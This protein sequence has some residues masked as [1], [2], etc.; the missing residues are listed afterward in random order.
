MYENKNLFKKII[1]RHKNTASQL[2]HDLHNSENLSIASNYWNFKT[3][4]KDY[5]RPLLIFFKMIFFTTYNNGK[6]NA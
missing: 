5:N 6:C 2:Y 3:F 1:K 4:F